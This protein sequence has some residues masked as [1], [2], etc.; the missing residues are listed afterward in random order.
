MPTRAE[1]I[2]EA[3]KRGHKGVSTKKK[4]ELEALLSKPPPKPARGVPRGMDK[5]KKAGFIRKEIAKG[6]LKKEGGRIVK[7][8]KAGGG[9]KPAPKAKAKPA[10]VKAGPR[11]LIKGFGIKRT[12]K[13]APKPAPKPKEKKPKAPKDG[14]ILVSKMTYNKV[15]PEEFV[16][17]SEE[18]FEYGS[19]YL[20]WDWIT[21]ITSSMEDFYKENKGDYNELS[22]A[23]RKKIDKIEEKMMMNLSPSVERELKKGFKTW[24]SK[25]ADD[26][27]TIEE[28]RD[29]FEKYYF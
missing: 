7:A 18:E 23:K 19:E 20:N 14:K 3:K 16:Y 25:N 4:A 11:N 1:L 12:P 21:G 22:E 24:K 8:G 5:S 13:P 27:M 9:T 15:V 26:R 29:R 28:A 6:V 10:P 2:A 17:R